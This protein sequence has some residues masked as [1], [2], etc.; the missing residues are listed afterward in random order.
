MPYAMPL[1]L[2]AGVRTPG[3]APLCVPA[4]LPRPQ[5]RWLRAVGRACAAL[6]L[7]LGLVALLT[8]CGFRLRGEQ[9]F[10]FATVAVTPEKGGAVAAE[11][12]RNLGDKVRPLV[13]AAG[14][15]LPDAVVD[16]LL[17]QREK[18]IAALNASG[19]VREYQL[20]IK[21]RFRLRTPQGQELIAPTDILQERDISFNESAVLAKEAEE[22]QIYRDMQSDIVQ[23]LLR[24]IAAVQSLTP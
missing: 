13:P 21:V 2:T 20:R 23:Q 16:I 15:A 11:L 18:V 19:Q 22:V 1:C 8:G 17:E 4:R 5:W 3:Q 7:V 14:G 12:A 9:T 24:R 6:L 10:A